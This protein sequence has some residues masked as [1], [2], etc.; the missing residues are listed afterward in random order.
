MLGFLLARCVYPRRAEP[1]ADPYWAEMLIAHSF[2]TNFIVQNVQPQVELSS[3][4]NEGQ[5]K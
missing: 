4:P 2:H 5:G 1:A 3:K